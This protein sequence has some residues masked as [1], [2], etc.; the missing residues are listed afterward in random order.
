MVLRF[1]AIG[2]F[3]F[4]ED[5]RHYSQRFAVLCWFL[6]IRY[7][8]IDEIALFVFSI[9]GKA[10]LLLDLRSFCLV[11]FSW[12][13][14]TRIFDLQLDQQLISEVESKVGID[15]LL[16]IEAIYSDLG[17]IAVASCLLLTDLE[18]TL[19]VLAEDLVCHGWVGREGRRDQ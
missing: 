2:D 12:N 17:L 9:L 19:F 8:L 16:R 15:V 10:E 18:I 3:D 7:L 11:Q 5:L 4:G 14:Q 1:F 6:E 13:L